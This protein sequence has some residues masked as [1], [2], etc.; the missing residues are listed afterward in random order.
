ML[1]DRK[2]LRI[3]V[4][5]NK[6]LASVSS[7][8]YVLAFVSEN[9][10]YSSLPAVDEVF[11]AFM[12]RLSLLVVFLMMNWIYLLGTETSASVQHCPKI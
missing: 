5:F 4:L 1:K 2:D 10:E 6:T 3:L 8:K 11:S 7:I 12:T 9:G